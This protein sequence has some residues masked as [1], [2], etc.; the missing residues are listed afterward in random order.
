MWQTYLTFLH[1]LKPEL[2]RQRIER[3]LALNRRGEVRDDGM[4]LRSATTRMA[5]Q[6]WARDVHPWDRDRP[7]DQK[8]AL[9]TDQMLI[10]TE[11]A[12]SR[13][14]RAL[15]HLDIVELV[16]LDPHSGDA[17][18][19]GVVE[20]DTWRR[21]RSLLSVRMRLGELGLRLRSAA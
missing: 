4:R 1:W 2:Y 5:L 17:L 19:A 9:F 7:E 8:R 12:V 15:P 10:D 14:F 11:A 20:R 13:V 16:V 21:P 3:A 18:I 6:V